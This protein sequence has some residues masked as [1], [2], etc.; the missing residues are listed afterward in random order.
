[1]T[2]LV[3]VSKIMEGE[4]PDRPNEQDLT[5]SVWDT[6]VRCWQED[7]V[8][9]PRMKEVAATLR[10][11]CVFPSLC[12]TL[13]PQHIPISCS[14]RL[15]VSAAQPPVLSDPGY[16]H[17]TFT[18]VATR[19][20]YTSQQVLVSPGPGVRPPTV[21]SSGSL[22]SPINQLGVIDTSR[23]KATTLPER[24]SLELLYI[25][26]SPP[27]WTRNFTVTLKYGNVT[28]NTVQAHPV[29]GCRD[30]KEWCAYAHFYLLPAAKSHAG[31]PCNPF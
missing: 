13:K 19:T 15:P 6:T 3:A 27:S 4:R 12:T 31:G 7:P 23:G 30:R 24:V 8:L 17:C 25:K 10:E 26:Y 9:R 28:Y 1:M 2:D 22:P 20:S 16:V 18:R 5:D 21:E 11:W 14:L 29:I